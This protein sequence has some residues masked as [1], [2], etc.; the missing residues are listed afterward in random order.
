MSLLCMYAITKHILIGID[1]MHI[2]LEEKVARLEKL[3]EEIVRL[4]NE[5]GLVDS[6]T[7]N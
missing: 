5:K 3:R 2:L 6:V 4:L 1:V 7:V